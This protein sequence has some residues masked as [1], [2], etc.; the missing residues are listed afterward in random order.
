M[1]GLPRISNYG[2][3]SS[4]NYGAHTL[5][6]SVGGLDVYFS[7]RTAIAFRSLK[8]GLVCSANHWGATTGKHLNWINPDKKSRVKSSVEFEERFQEALKSL[9]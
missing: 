9:K 4:T 6:V 5:V 7:Y 2:K 3:Y 8:T 1:S